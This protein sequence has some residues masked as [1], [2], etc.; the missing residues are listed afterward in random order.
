MSDSALPHDAAATRADGPGGWARPGALFGRALAALAACAGRLFPL[1]PVCLSAGIAT[2]FALPREPGTAALAVVAGVM[3]F[4]AAGWLRGPD[5]LRAP[6][7]GLA[8]ALAGVLLAEARSHLVAAP[9]LTFRLYGAVEGR[10]IDIDRS[11]SD[12][13]RVTLDQ[14]SVSGLAPDRTPARIRISLKPEA[15]SPAPPLPEP[16]SRVRLVANLGPPPG[17]AEPGGFDFRRLAWFDRLGAIGFA[18]DAPETLAPADPADPSV[19]A[20]RTRM[21][22]SQSMQDRIPGQPGALAAAFMTGD[23]SAITVATNQVMRDSSL[24]HLVSISGVHMSLVAATVLLFVRFGLALIPAVALRTDTRK[25]A[26]VAALVATT[27]Y[28]ILAGADAATERSWIMAAVMLTAVLV[29]R[30]AV[31]LRS[32]ALAAVAIL[33][34]TPESLVEPGFQMSF[35]ATV[36]LVV[37]FDGWTRAQNRLPVLLRPVALTVIASLVAGLATGPIAAAHFG[38]FSGY[39]FFANL[40]AAPVMGVIVMPAGVLAAVAAP[41]GLAD[42]PLWVTGLGCDLIL[43]IATLFA[44]IEGAARIV[45]AAPALAL[46]TIA[47]SGLLLLLPGR[48]TKL[49]GLALFAGLATVWAAAP[50]PDVLIASDGALVGTLED[51]GLRALSKARGAGLFAE[52]WLRADGDPAPQ[53]EAAARPA[54]S[55]PRAAR[56]AVWQGRTL[57]HFTGKRALADARAACQ[58][59]AI[60]VLT[61]S[62]G[63]RPDGPCDVFDQWRLRRTGAIALWAEPGGGYRVV[64]ANDAAG[65]RPWSRSAAPRRT[66]AAADPA[67]GTASAVPGG[68]GQ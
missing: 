8:L 36:A 66:A 67:P 5:L 23:R 28:F 51:S 48:W 52:R 64:T 17:P 9:V 68:H 49:S 25:I 1:V 59:G 29:D 27:A 24:Y 13:I 18:R 10:V 45:P 33:V 2:Y 54:F 31:S 21:A 56:M 55:G 4:A 65:D 6:L 53:S 38:R 20:F 58:G 16:G 30:R 22:L 34:T 63:G 12:A 37:A 14:L 19:M 62:W 39:G 42:L 43:R 44:A 7:A 50:R 35:A 3:V 61:E 41:F 11:T 32:V 57:G 15:D 40:V 47:L 26:A 46:P 60:L